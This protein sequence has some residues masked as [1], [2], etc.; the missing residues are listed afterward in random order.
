MNRTKL[1]A[2]IPLFY[3]YSFLNSFLLDRAIWMLVLVFQGFL[4]SEVSLIES[5]YHCAIFLL[6]VPAGYVADRYGKRVS[7]LA[8]ELAGIVPSG[9]LLAGGDASILAYG[10][11]ERD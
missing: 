9:L 2:K 1:A 6:E 3:V 4:L 7:L 5:A 11:A 8:A 10:Q